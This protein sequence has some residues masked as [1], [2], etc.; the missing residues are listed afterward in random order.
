M[1]TFL[2][3]AAAAQLVHDALS[4]SDRVNQFTRDL[5]VLSKDQIPLED[6]CPI[7]LVPFLEILN[8][9]QD[10]KPNSSSTSLEDDAGVTKLEGCGHIFCRRELVISII[11]S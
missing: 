10:S 8:T 4:V 3:R 7:C 11:E 2:A 6:N 5:P 9:P 1:D